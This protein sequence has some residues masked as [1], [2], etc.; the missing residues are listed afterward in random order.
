VSV[1]ALSDGPSLDMNGP[2]SDD[3]VALNDPRLE[4]LIR[5]DPTQ[6][7]TEVERLIVEIAQP[8]IAAILA[9]YSRARSGLSPA[10][11]DDIG[12]TISLRLLTKLR[13]LATSSDDSIQD[14]EKY[15]ATLIYNAVNDHLRKMFPAR[16]RLKNRLRYALT[17]DPRLALW[18]ADGMLLCGL[19]AWAGST[20]RL[21]E[22]PIEASRAT[23]TILNRDRPTD[24]LLSI[25]ELA[26]EPIIFEALVTFTVDAWHIVDL[27]PDEDLST[28]RPETG[29]AAQLEMRQ[30]LATLW[31][32]IRKLRPM[33]RKALLLNLRSGETSNVISLVVLTGVASIDEVAATLEMTPRDLA[34]I[35]NELPLD[36]NRIAALLEVPRQKVINLRKSA[37]ERL[38]RRMDR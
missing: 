6:R 1:F 25:F 2:S 4:R 21:S 18:T 5:A 31:E 29:T 13:S 35:W 36:D 12:A 34:G 7:E 15:L 23:R 10:D 8:L 22:V 37:R 11:V 24:A 28:R 14:F 38:S 19:Q 17:H 30:Y 16:A 32:E 3:L 26:G 20:K 9:R 27:Q 33:Q